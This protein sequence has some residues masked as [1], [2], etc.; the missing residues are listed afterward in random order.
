MDPTTAARLTAR[1]IDALGQDAVTLPD[2]L[3]PSQKIDWWP[4]DKMML[5]QGI[6]DTATPLCL[7][8][9][10]DTKQLAHALSLAHEFG[11][12]VVPYG[13]G[14][15]VSGGARARAG[16]VLMSTR[17]LRGEIV[18]DEQNLTVRVPA[19]T[20]LSDLERTVGALGYTT[21]HYPQSIDLATIGGLLAT[22]SAGQFSN[23]Y[24]NI[25]DMTLGCTV[26]L[27][28]G[29]IVEID[30]SPRRSTGPDLLAVFIGSEGTL[31][32]I[33]EVKLALTRK[34]TGQ[35]EQA[36][37]FTDWDQGARAL[38][39]VFQSGWSPAVTRLYDAI[40]TPIHVHSD[41][42]PAGHVGLLVLGEGPAG[43]VEAER[44]AV[45]EILSAMGGTAIGGAPVL[46]WLEKRNNTGY[47]ER[48]FAEGAII[49]TIEIAAEWTDL[50][51]LYPRVM[52]RARAVPE[53]ERIS[54]HISHCY[55][56]GANIY[57]SVRATWDREADPRVAYDA[58][59]AAVLEG[60]LESNGS[61]SHHHGIGKVRTAWMQ[62]EHGSSYGV[63]RSIKE[64]LDPKCT[65]NPGTLLPEHS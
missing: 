16:G 29:S 21:G 14:S 26:V 55:P 34:A 32:V 5:E 36:Y 17:G 2:A 38:R 33:A 65:L 39:E 23:K 19:G 1:L 49:D 30:N 44:V 31:G 37:T 15:G 64:A 43:A 25:E 27:V 24:G 10:A 51:V 9:P 63:L 41:A 18:V 46:H 54:G 13:G 35:W 28:D 58:M 60:T 6:L 4:I 56:A 62:R 48:S 11:A 45:G 8:E 53:L 61:I 59:W 12:E 20:L 40:E 50:E 57:F 22:R 42:I 3:R 52:E 47:F 7:V